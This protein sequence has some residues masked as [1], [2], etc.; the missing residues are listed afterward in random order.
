L[1]A[2]NQ[3]LAQQVIGTEQVE[4]VLVDGTGWGY[5]LPMELRWC[6]GRQIRRCRSHG[7]GW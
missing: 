7:K 3:W 1:Q 4:I 2:F 6:R 5:S